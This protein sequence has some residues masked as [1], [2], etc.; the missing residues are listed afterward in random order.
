MA[1]GS[2]R[3]SRQVLILLVVV[4]LAAVATAWGV[5][6]LRG[7]YSAPAIVLRTDNTKATA[8]SPLLLEQR[9]IEKEQTLTESD[10]RIVM[11][12]AC[13]EELAVEKVSSTHFVIDVDTDQVFR[14][15]FMFRIEGAAGR[16]VRIDL[17]N[18][19]IQKWTTLNPVYSELTDLDDP[20]GFVSETPAD[21]RPQIAPNGPLLPDTRGQ[22]WHFISAVWVSGDNTLSMVHTFEQDVIHVAMRYPYTPGYNEVFMASLAGHRAVQVFTVGHSSGGQPLQILKIGGDDEADRQRPCVLLYGREYA[23]S[24]D[25]SWVV[26]GAARFLLSDDPQAVA[27]REQV[28]FLLIPLIDPDGALANRFDHY[29]RAYS[30]RNTLPDALAYAAWFERWVDEEKRLDV[31]ISFHNTESAFGEHLFCVY[32]DSGR[33]EPCLAL[34]DAILDQFSDGAFNV[35]QEA[36][37]GYTI[38]QL[39]GFLGYY[40]GPLPLLYQLNSQEADYHLTLHDL[41]EIGRRIALGC[42]NY[43]DSSEAEEALV[44]IQYLRAGRKERLANVPADL[45]PIERANQLGWNTVY[46]K[47]EHLQRLEG[48]T[49]QP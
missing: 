2:E 42:G 18:A 4:L 13:S 8:T 27:L 11:G 46:A 1:D 34:H 15:W 44:G 24:H 22:Q 28:T 21:A 30:E 19:P 25:T 38:T 33:P 31:A 20:A 47:R 10:I 40:Y 6:H 3:F 5:L 12:F 14:N 7:Q 26:E 35:R 45:N 17:K 9:R 48:E 32:T 49:P 37:S 41:R 36:G 16:T 39:N 43:F 23:T 29:N